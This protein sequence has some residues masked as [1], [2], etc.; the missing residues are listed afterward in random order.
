MPQFP[1]INTASAKYRLQKS[2][3]Q[4]CAVGKFHRSEN[5]FQQSQ[6]NQQ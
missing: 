2:N 3:R 4:P 1:Y 5:I 6:I